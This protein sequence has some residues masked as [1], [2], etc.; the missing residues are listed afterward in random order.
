M[1]QLIIA[2]FASL[3]PDGVPKEIVYIPEGHHEIH[4]MVDGKP[5]AI[6]V[7]DSW[8]VDAFEFRRIR[9]L[10]YGH[11]RAGLLGLS[12]PGFDQTSLGQVLMVS[13][14]VPTHPS[15]RRH[16]ARSR[17]GQAEAQDPGNP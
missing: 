9:E 11:H 17:D 5:K 7:A 15:N 12:M 8:G 4:P 1:R 6:T 2:A 10:G 3:L 14:V 16:G 13:G